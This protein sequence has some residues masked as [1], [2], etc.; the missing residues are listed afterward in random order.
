MST[1]MQYRISGLLRGFARDERGATAIEY[2]LIAALVAV[3]MLAGLKTL[4][5]GNSGSWDSTAN[6]A[7][8]AV[9]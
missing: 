5:S 9:K 6:K 7:I 3:V 2:G 8:N 1:A 4:G